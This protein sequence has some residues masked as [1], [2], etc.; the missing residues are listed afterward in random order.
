MRRLFIRQ[1][2]TRIHRYRGD[3]LE[4]LAKQVGKADTPCQPAYKAPFSATSIKITVCVTAKM[5]DERNAVIAAK[6]LLQS[7]LVAHHIQR[8]LL[9]ATVPRPGY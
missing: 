8:F 9:L 6:L 4:G 3:L 1:K 5:D 2:A 7:R